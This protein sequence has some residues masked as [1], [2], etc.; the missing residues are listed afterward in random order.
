[1]IKKIKKQWFL[2]GLVMVFAAVMVDQTGVLSDFGFFLKN[3]YG[4][5]FVIFIIFLLSGM[6]IKT[7]QIKSG[8]RDVK[9]TFAALSVIFIVSPI[10]AAALSF[11]PVEPG[12]VIGLFIVAV[13]PTTLSSGVVMTGRAGGN[14]A[15]ALFITILANFISIV[16]IPF[17]LSWLVSL[18]GGHS[19]ITIDQYAIMKKL[20]FLVLMPMSAGM[21]LKALHGRIEEKII[22]NMQIANQVFVICIVFM[23]ASGAREIFIKK[24]GS[25]GYVLA[26]VILFHLSLLLFSFFLSFFLKIKKGRRESQIFMG[27][28]KT[29]PLSVILQVTLFPEF[30]A[31]LLVCVVH[32]IVHLVIDSYL[33]VRLGDQKTAAV[34]T[35]LELNN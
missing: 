34:H 33:A 6:I 21:F 11:L 28:Q 4:P 22:K 12:I 5:D 1:M 32:H 17:V 18:L 7:E 13:M 8:L 15:H 30:G 26:M 19:S 10:V 23:A 3:N 29:L 16:S 31:A 25:I 14:M 9:V 24:S 2:M 27:S 20:F 35:N